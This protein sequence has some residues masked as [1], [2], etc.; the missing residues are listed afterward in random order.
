MR[1]R[2]ERGRGRSRARA[3]ALDPPTSPS[4]RS[5]FDFVYPGK[6]GTLPV[7]T[8]E[9]AL[10]IA[11]GGYAGAT[12]AQARAA[13]RCAVVLRDLVAPYL[14]RRRKADVAS[15]LPPKTERVLFCAL[16]PA[17]R[18]AYR[19][20]LASSDVAD[21]L[22]GRRSALAGI[23]TLRKI[24]NHPDLLQRTAWGDGGGYGD[25]VRAL[26][27]RFNLGA[28]DAQAAAFFRGKVHSAT[29]SFTTAVYDTIQLWQNKI[30]K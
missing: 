13:F 4:S 8:A 12:R 14:L 24:C 1:Q 5:L 2:R 7:F 20:F 19:A 21:V 11:A 3:P 27:E 23:D 9:F 15:Q 26:R 29:E 6:L 25:P 30:P 18:D 28:T 22:A 17:Q 10:P 16:A